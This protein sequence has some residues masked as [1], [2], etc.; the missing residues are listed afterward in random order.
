AG[1]AID[2]VQAWDDVTDE[3]LKS[4]VIESDPAAVEVSGEEGGAYP[5]AR[6]RYVL[7]SVFSRP[8]SFFRG[9]GGDLCFRRQTNMPLVTVEVPRGWEI[10]RA[11]PEGET[12]PGGV[13]YRNPE[14]ELFAISLDLIPSAE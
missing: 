2:R 9:D 10:S 14:Q 6:G 4:S 12:V 7:D 13:R 1:T 8:E 5:S 3:D 11:E